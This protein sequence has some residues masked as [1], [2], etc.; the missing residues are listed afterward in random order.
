MFKC[1]DATQCQ[2]SLFPWDESR[3]YFQESLRDS[4]EQI[5]VNG[6]VRV[7]GRSI[8]AIL[9]TC[10]VKA[11]LD[12]LNSEKTMSSLRPCDCC[13]DQR[14]QV[15]RA[16]GNA[17]DSSDFGVYGLAVLLTIEFGVCQ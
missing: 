6:E 1:R 10:A 5:R 2:R 8:L 16:A 15:R 17:N 7:K 3:G 4:T 9:N 12:F 14:S 11:K 13:S